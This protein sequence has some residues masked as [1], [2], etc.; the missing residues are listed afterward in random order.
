MIFM[1][2]FKMPGMF[3][4]DFFIIHNFTLINHVLLAWGRIRRIEDSTMVL[5][6]QMML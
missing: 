6:I 5:A 1:S 3:A 4:K 2:H